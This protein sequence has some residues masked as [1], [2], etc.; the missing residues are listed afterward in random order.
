MSTS[1]IAATEERAALQTI[2]QGLSR[3]ASAAPPVDLPAAE[4]VKRAK[5]VFVEKT[6]ARVALDLESC[7]HCG[8]CAEACHFYEGTGNGRYAPI[9]KL[10]LLRKVYRRELGPFR[11]IQK[12]LTREIT[13]AELEQWQELVFDSCT[14]CGRCDMICPVGVH[15]SRGVH[16]TRQA[17]TAAGLAPAELRALDAE[18]KVTGTLFGAGVAQLRSALQV[19]QA[20]GIAAP[21]DKPQAEYLLLTTAT[22]L[23]VY[24][25]SLAATARILNHLGFDWTFSSTG[26]E[27]ANSGAVSGDEAAQRQATQRIVDAAQACGA[28]FV[29]VPECGHAYPALRWEGPNEMG[30][31]FEFE[32]LAISEL[33][34]RELDSGKL[35]LKPLGKDKHVTFHDPCKFGRKGG[36]IDAPRKALAA[37]DVDL[38]ETESKGTTNYCCGGGGGV[39]FIGRAAPLRNAAFNIKRNQFDATGAE[40]VVTSCG[41][42]RMNFAVGAQRNNWEM[43]VESLVELV[44]DNLGTP[45]TTAGQGGTS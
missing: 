4:R 22:D 28:R 11:F 30:R 13:V 8:M 20:Q 3:L 41:S 19:L 33:I 32:V 27:A 25:R 18:Q 26:F 31:A 35:Q 36:V 44:A 43:P 40:S 29:V 24:R 6:D 37:L 34:G 42:C 5:R 7:L 45:A 16:I 9:H 14:E 23:L 39:F 1:T 38:R 12:L 15:L 17:L 2:T 10:K 21:L